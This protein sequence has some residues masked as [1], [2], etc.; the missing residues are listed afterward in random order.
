MHKIYCFNNGGSPRWL[1]AIAIADDGHVLVQ[2]VCSDEYYMKHDLGITSDWKHENYDKHFGPGNW[3]LVWIA[4]P[5]KSPEL[6]AAFELNKALPPDVAEKD[7]EATIAGTT[8]EF[9]DGTQVRTGP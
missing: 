4:D 8:G 5:G 2:H 3:E 6:D 1:H 9:S 7:Y